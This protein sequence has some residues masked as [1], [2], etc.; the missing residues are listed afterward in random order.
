MLFSVLLA[1]SSPYL[2]IFYPFPSFVFCL[3]FYDLMYQC[4]FLWDCFL[5][6]LSQLPHGTSI[7]FSCFDFIHQSTIDDPILLFTL[8]RLQFPVDLVVPLPSP[9]PPRLAV[10]KLFCC[11]NVFLFASLNW[12]FLCPSPIKIGMDREVIGKSSLINK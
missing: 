12:S 9:P 5:G 7:L 10:R 2:S 1:C 4:V 11:G 6:V 8:C 3:T